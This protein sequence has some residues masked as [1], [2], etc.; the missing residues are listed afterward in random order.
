MGHHLLR[1]SGVDGAD[2]TDRHAF[3][4]FDTFLRVNLVLR[5]HIVNG[6]GRTFQRAVMTAQTE[7]FD[8]IG[9]GSSILS[10]ISP[11]FYRIFCLLTNADFILWYII[12]GIGII[13][14][15]LCVPPSAC[16]S[17]VQK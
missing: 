9:H 12:Y 4:A 14:D 15:A 2:I 3:S 5:A 11:L 6:V 10:F 1:L 7:G 17:G 8:L 16:L 13:S